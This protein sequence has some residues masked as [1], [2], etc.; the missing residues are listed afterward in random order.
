VDLIGGRTR[1]LADGL[2]VSALT[3]EGVEEL[4]AEIRR[5]LIPSRPAGAEP[6]G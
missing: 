3:G 5:R 6:A 2:M 1:S 4:R